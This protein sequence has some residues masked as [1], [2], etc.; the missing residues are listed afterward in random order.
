[1][2]ADLSHD[3]SRRGFL[4]LVGLGGGTLAVAGAGGLTWRAVSE[5][6]FA[7]GTGPAYAAWDRWHQPQSSV[8]NLVRAA[9]LAAN[10][11]N[12]QPW[13]FHIGQ[14]SIDLYADPRRGMGSMD[15]LRREMYLSLG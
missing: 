10:A 11:H 15:P 12:T 3:I 14:D 13:L 6:V 1:M 4:S 9:V 2:N 8:L 5:G 7:T